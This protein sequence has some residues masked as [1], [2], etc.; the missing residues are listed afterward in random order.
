M[1][2]ASETYFRIM[3]NDVQRLIIENLKEGEKTTSQ[4]TEAINRYSPTGIP[5]L[6][7]YLHAWLLEQKGFVESRGEGIERTY[8]LTDKWRQLEAEAQKKS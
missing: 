3:T 5:P 8:R 6:V 4:L 7:V 1:S 2:S